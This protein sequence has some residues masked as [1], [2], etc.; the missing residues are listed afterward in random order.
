[1]KHLSS[2]YL[3]LF[4]LSCFDMFSTAYLHDLGLVEE[5]G[6][7]MFIVLEYGYV[8][9][10]LA[11]V[12]LN[13]LGFGLLWIRRDHKWALGVLGLV[14]MPLCFICGLHVVLLLSLFLA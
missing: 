14:G 13:V 4:V 3:F 8:T 12:L 6:P 2:L 5:A 11:H 10:F 1:M 7:F 9:F